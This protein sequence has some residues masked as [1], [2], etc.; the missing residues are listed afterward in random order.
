MKS[1]NLLPTLITASLLLASCGQN[2]ADKS[3]S[4]SNSNTDTPFVLIGAMPTFL[5]KTPDDSSK[6]NSGS[7]KCAISAGT[8]LLLQSDP[9]TDGAHLIVNTEQVLAGC[10]FSKGYIY[11]PHVERSSVKLLFSPTVSAFLDTIGYAE[12]TG[13][14]YDYIYTHKVFF[15]YNGHP[16]DLQCSAGLCSDAAGRYQFLS[17]T[18]D[19]IRK[20]LGL[21]DFSPPSQDRAAVQLMKDVGCYKFVENINGPETFSRAASCVSGQWAS[22]PSS[23]YGQKKYSSSHLYEKFRKF[24]ERY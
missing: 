10:G 1:L 5:K 19:G 21:S 4:F 8:K 16:R 3:E 14:R 13:D 22:F 9:T 20:R 2:T 6:L 11:R 18:W 15:S 23:Q 17:T 24:M 7:G 12:G